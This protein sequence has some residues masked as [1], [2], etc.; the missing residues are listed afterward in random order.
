MSEMYSESCCIRA[1]SRT[2]GIKRV[3]NEVADHYG[4]FVSIDTDTYC[5]G[6]WIFKDYRT[7]YNIRFGGDKDKVKEAI[8][9]LKYSCQCYNSRIHV[10]PTAVSG[11]L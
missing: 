7:E 4:L 2:M 11:F 1:D 5:V 9:Q 10:P 6:G 8:R 3:A